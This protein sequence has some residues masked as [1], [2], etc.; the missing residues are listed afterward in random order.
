MSAGKVSLRTETDHE[1]GRITSFA[2][3]EVPDVDVQD[4]E[5]GYFEGDHAGASS[6]TFEA[7]ALAILHALGFEAQRDLGPLPPRRAGR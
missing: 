2:R 5:L 6:V 4:V 3:I 7:G 1:H